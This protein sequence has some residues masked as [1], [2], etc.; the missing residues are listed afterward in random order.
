MN[1]YMKHFR[2]LLFCIVCLAVGSCQKENGITYTKVNITIDYPDDIA[3]AEPS[4]ECLEFYNI[5]TGRTTVFDSRDNITL[6]EGLYDCTYS[7]DLQSSDEEQSASQLHGY[8]SA[9]EVTGEQ[10]EIRL[11][12]FPLDVKN[13]FIIQEIFFTG[14]LQPS[15]KQYTGDS[16]IKIYNNTD[17]VLYANGLALM[18]SKFTTTQKFDYSPDLMSTHMTVQAVYV[19]PGNGTEHPVQPGES[20]LLCDTGI[21][22]RISNPNSFDLSQAD[23]EWYD[24][25]SS[26]SNMDIDSPTVPNLDKWYCYTKSIWVLHNRG[27]K[28]YALA[29]IPVDKETF[30]KDYPYTYNYL[31]VLPAGTFPMSQSA[32]KIPNEWIVDA[33]NASVASEYVWNVTDA[34]LDR[35]YTHCGTIDHDKT[36]YFKSVRRKLLYKTRDGRCVLK[37]TNNSADDFNSECIPSIVEEQQ[38]ATDANGTPA[39]VQTYDGVTP[40]T[41]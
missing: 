17:H 28:A 8:T 25:S 14:T 27:F 35:G 3:P 11:S 7:A 21:D 13:D 32:Y 12:V 6:P 37:D 24:I 22:H 40:I 29:R 1:K 41:D 33:V 36:R 19:I 15:G 10:C 18:E 9:V 31:Q 2:F 34:S 16:F 26:P 30:L 38:T 39:T 5:S 4:A 20:L 23:F